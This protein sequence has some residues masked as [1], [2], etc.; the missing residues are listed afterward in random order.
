MGRG[1]SGAQRC[2][3]CEALA[4]LFVE[5]G[6]LLGVLVEHASRPLKLGAEAKSLFLQREALPARR[7][8]DA[9]DE[10]AS[11]GWYVMVYHGIQRHATA[12]NGCN[13][14]L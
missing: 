2:V 4:Q 9:L 12:R 3:T 1:A 13:G 10:A 7:H 11:L 6:A 8:R 14:A 5:G